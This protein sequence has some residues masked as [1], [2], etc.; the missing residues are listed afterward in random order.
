MKRYWHSIQK[1]VY[2]KRFS[3]RPFIFAYNEFTLLCDLRGKADVIKKN[4]LK[5]TAA[6]SRLKCEAIYEI[7]IQILMENSNE[8]WLKMRM[9]HIKGNQHIV[10]SHTKAC[11][12]RYNLKCIC[13]PS[14]YHTFW[15][16]KPPVFYTVRAVMKT[17]SS[18]HLLRFFSWAKQIKLD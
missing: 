18:I 5:A 3:Y 9:S 8:R 14:H 4:N 2:L 16:G 17:S 6:I 10:I 11:Q 1:N 12:L 13:K 15:V 7:I